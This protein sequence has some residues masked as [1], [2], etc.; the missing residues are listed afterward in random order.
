MD[1]SKYFR[2]ETIDGITVLT[3]D[4]KEVLDRQKLADLREAIAAL[5][6]EENPEKLVVDFDGLQYCTSEFIGVLIRA[7][8][9]LVKENGRIDLCN[10]QPTIREV[11]KTLNLDGTMFRIHENRDEALQSIRKTQP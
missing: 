4:G 8:R 9:K 2:R 1:E 11:F 7:H 5:V 10:L 6:D 3:L